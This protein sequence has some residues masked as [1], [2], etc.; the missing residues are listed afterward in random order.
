MYIITI[1]NW[2]NCGLSI[3][4]S[5]DS[6]TFNQIFFI[7]IITMKIYIFYDLY[8]F[9]FYY[10]RT[11]T[12]SSDYLCFKRLSTILFLLKGDFCLVLKQHESSKFSILF[13]RYHQFCS[14]L[15]KFFALSHYNSFNKISVLSF[16]P[17][18][19]VHLY[20]I[21][22]T[23]IVAGIHYPISSQYCIHVIDI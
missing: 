15:Y 9:K 14:F 1:V 10:T 17:P 7:N 20:P 19:Y 11:I 12:L 22:I 6:S 2:S 5:Q 8:I 16:S 21:P 3:D 4:I 13:H 18:F 23:S